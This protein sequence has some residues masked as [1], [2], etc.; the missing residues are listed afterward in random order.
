MGVNVLQL[1]GELE[2]TPLDL[3]TDGF[4]RGDNILSFVL[5]EQANFGQH[6]RVSLASL[7][8]LTKEPAVDANRFRERFDA[9]VGVALKSPAPGFFTHSKSHSTKTEIAKCKL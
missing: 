5:R 2:L 9:L 4:E 8:V 1:G 6:A 3:P 7:D